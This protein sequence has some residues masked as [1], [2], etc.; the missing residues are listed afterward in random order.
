MNIGVH[1]SLSDLVSLVCMPRS[2]IAGSYGWIRIESPEINPQAYGHL[3]F[4]KGGKDIQWKKDSLFNKWCWENWSTSC[5]RMKLEHFLTPYTKI[6]SK[7][8]KDL[9]VTPETIK[10]HGSFFPSLSANSFNCPFMNLKFYLVL[11]GPEL[12]PPWD[13]HSSE[14]SL[15]MGSSI[16]LL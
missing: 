6:N 16:H 5:K 7:W 11:L 12:L 14:L 3:I 4:N 1:V 13:S 10:L 2:G 15:L 9:N 8:I